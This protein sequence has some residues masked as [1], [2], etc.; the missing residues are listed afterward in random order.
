M[1]GWMGARAG[2]KTVEK[3]K[4]LFPYGESVRDSMEGQRIA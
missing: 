4:N 2:L 3:R 1:G